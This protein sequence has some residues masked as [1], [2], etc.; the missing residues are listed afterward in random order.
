M[1]PA[2]PHSLAALLPP[3]RGAFT[4]PTFDTFCWLVH[5]FIGRERTITGVW[6]AARLVGVLHHSRAHGFIARRRCHP[7][8]WGCSR[9]GWGGSPL[10]LEQRTAQGSDGASDSLSPVG[11]A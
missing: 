6:Q 4:A 9:L 11:T 1:P 7:T 2:L 8:A 3:L 10:G 5:G